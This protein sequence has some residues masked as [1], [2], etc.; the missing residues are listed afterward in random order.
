MSQNT[1]AIISI[2]IAVLSLTVSVANVIWNIRKDRR[3]KGQFRLTGM[4][5]KIHP[6]PTDNYY[7]VIGVTNIGRRPTLLKGWALSGKTSSGEKKDYLGPIAGLPKM[8]QE[9]ENHALQVGGPEALSLEY[10]R[11]YV[12]DAAG[13]EWDLDKKAIQEINRRTLETG[14][15][16][17]SSK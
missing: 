16:K 7:L 8:L 17:I 11:I 15:R 4:L 6:D 14:L 1:V 3:D 13:N 12:F 9:Q 10:T 5:G 2:V